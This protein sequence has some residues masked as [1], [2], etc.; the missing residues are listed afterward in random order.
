MRRYLFLV[1]S[2]CLFIFAIHRESNL[3]RLGR[4]RECFLSAMP[5][6]RAILPFCWF[7]LIVYLFL[8]AENRTQ[9]AWVASAYVS[10]LLCR[11]PCNPTSYNLIIFYKYSETLEMVIFLFFSFV[12]T[13]RDSVAAS[14]TRNWRKV[15]PKNISKWSKNSASMSHMMT[16]MPNLKSWD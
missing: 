6:P 3:G 11:P 16:S 5:F 12:Q 14:P 8:P 4:K 9:V 2:H 1:R 13:F 7:D 15:H 10:S